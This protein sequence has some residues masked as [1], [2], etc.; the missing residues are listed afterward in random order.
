MT[1]IVCPDCGAKIDVDEALERR[2]GD[3]VLHKHL[4]ELEEVKKQAILETKDF[5]EKKARETIE[6]DRNEFNLE[7]EKMKS[8]YEASQ[9]TNEELKGKLSE[10]LDKIALLTEQSS[11]REL[12]VKEL[13]IRT[14][15]DAAKEARDKSDESWKLKCS[16]LEQ[17]L[18]NTTKSLQEALSRSEQGSQQIQG[19]VLEEDIC[20]CLRESFR[21][22]DIERVRKGVRGADVVQRVKFQNQ[23][24]GTIIWETKNAKW[25]AQWIS[26]L[27]E[28]VATAKANVGVLV[29]VNVPEEIGTFGTVQ[30][31]LVTK[32]SF[33]MPLAAILRLNILDIRNANMAARGRDEKMNCL[34]DYITGPE[35]RSRVSMMIES[36]EGLNKELESEM[37]TTNARWARQ[38]KRIDSLL[39][40]TAGIF[41]DFQGI[42]G[43]VVEDLPKLSV[44]L[45][46][47]LQ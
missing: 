5:F 4:Q 37:R 3:E 33:V 2:I 24:C 13:L 40:S 38:K 17:Q 22:D 32:P 21:D 26:K 8:D 20:D 30:G 12:E 27:K 47:T 34:L 23:E 45:S 35:F 6:N 11:T 1:M 42:M 14:R 41:G 39:I 15:E 36:Y 10:L 7:F 29:S 9:R 19:E 46:E 25:N 43:S 31:I 28:D 44:S 16:E 18:S